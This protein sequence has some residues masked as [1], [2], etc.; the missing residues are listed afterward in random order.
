MKLTRSHRSAVIGAVSAT[1]VLGVV[2]LPVASAAPSI[3]VTAT[4]RWQGPAPTRTPMSATDRAALQATADATLAG[5][6]GAIPGV[7]VG[8]WDPQK[9]WAIVSAGNAQVDGA[10]ATKVDHSRIG[11]VTKTFVATQILKLVDAGKLKLSSTIGDL[12]PAVAKAHPY[13]R[14]VTVKQML[15]MRSGIPDYTEVPGAMANAYNNPERR[16]TA[17]QLIELGLASATKLGEPKY[18]NTNY[19]LLGEIARKVTGR[20]IFDLVNADV[21]RL[22]MKQTRL[23]LPGRKAMPTPF[24]HGYNYLPGVIS[25]AASGVEVEVGSEQQDDVTQWGQAAGS[26]YSTV[27]DMG[28]WAATGLGL[29][30]LSPALAAKR[31]AAKPISGG[32]IQYGLGMERFGNNWVGH[33]GQAIGWE[34]RVAYNTK[35]GAAL[36]ILVNETGSLRNVLPIAADYFPDLVG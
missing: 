17:A 6:K 28:T 36:V 26:M 19:I 1:I 10:A 11:S 8:V 20:S 33:D 22:G 27:A 30:E 12:L 32:A 24:S 35:T 16:W 15:G 25:L 18:S 23:P 9:G 31:I 7:W 29:S 3:Q 4:D 13:V 21:R 5:W 14:N 2:A 34:S